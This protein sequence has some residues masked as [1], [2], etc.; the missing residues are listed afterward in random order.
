M[1]VFAI[2]WEVCEL[3]GCTSAESTPSER[4]DKMVT[5]DSDNKRKQ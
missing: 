4:G 1:F 3:P 2:D 5:V